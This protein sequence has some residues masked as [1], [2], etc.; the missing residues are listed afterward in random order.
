MMADILNKNSA[1]TN[2]E[3]NGPPLLGGED[4]A[5]F[6]E[7][8]P[9]CYFFLGCGNQEKGIIH[10]LHSSLFDIDETALEVALSTLHDIA[11]K[12]EEIVNKLRD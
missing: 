7:L 2:F 8:T 10:P 4:F 5:R 11:R 9:G 12:G 6:A 1:I 3:D